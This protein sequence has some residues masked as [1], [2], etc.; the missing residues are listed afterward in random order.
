MAYDLYSAKENEEKNL[1]VR[2]RC[3]GHGFLD[4]DVLV[5]FSLAQDQRLHDLCIYSLPYIGK[6]CQAYTA[7]LPTAAPNNDFQLLKSL[8]ACCS[9][10]AVPVILKAASCK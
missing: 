4:L 7:P 3:F 9:V 6:A 8:L 5:S 1:N 10:N 2:C